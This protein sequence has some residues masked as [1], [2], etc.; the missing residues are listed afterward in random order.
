MRRV[1]TEILQVDDVGVRRWGP[2]FKWIEMMDR[3]YGNM[4][5]GPS[6][7]AG[8]KKEIMMSLGG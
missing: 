6:S 4:K 1:G 5:Q 7:M 8:G 2:Q 3:N